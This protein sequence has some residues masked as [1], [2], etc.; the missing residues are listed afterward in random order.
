LVTIK[1]V[2]GH[3]DVKSTEIYVQ[4]DLAMKRHALTLVG[5]PARLGPR[6]GQLPKDVLDWLEAL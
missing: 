6:G 4:S 1:D 3:A 5:S 2:L